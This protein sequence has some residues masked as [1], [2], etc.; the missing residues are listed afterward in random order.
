MIWSEGDFLAGT[1]SWGW[2]CSHCKR[3][4]SGFDTASSAHDS[5]DQHEALCDGGDHRV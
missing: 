5:L 1:L 4:H 3:E 2:T